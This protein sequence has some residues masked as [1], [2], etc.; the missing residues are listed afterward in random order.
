M[1]KRKL[2]TG[3]TIRVIGYRPGKY[4]PGVVDD[5]GTEDLFRGMVGRCYR[6]RGFDDYRHIELRPKPLDT[7]W[8][9]ADLVELVENANAASKNQTCSIAP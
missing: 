9:E 3:K 6:I 1:A 5:M 4:A 2:K 7:V 8:I